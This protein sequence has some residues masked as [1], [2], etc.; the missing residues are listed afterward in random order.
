MRRMKIKFLDFFQ[1]IIN[2][3]LNINDL[4]KNYLNSVAKNQKEILI[5]Y[6]KIED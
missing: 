6:D 1:N 2:F 4:I 5:I 3:Q